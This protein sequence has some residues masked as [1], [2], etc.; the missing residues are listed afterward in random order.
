MKRADGPERVFGEWWKRDAEL[1]A[2]RDYFQ[3]EDENGEHLGSPLV[4]VTQDGI[5]LRL[6]VRDQLRRVGL[7]VG[8]LLR[9][10]GLHAGTEVL[11]VDVGLADEPQGLL[12]CNPQRVLQLGSEARVG[13][14][15]DLVELRLKVF[16]DRLETFDLLCLLGLVG[17][18]LDEIV[19]QA[20]DDLVDFVLLVSAQFSAER[21]FCR[22]R[23]APSEQKGMCVWEGSV[24]PSTR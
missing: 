1:A 17:V 15:A 2:V 9:K 19:S 6:S 8:P 7:D 14:A 12:L 16:G 18:R 3:V 13:R 22:H 23:F 21:V 20:A 24:C 5:H 10:L 4:R 11:G